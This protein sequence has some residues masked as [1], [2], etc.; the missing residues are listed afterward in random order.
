MVMTDLDYQHIGDNNSWIIG[1]GKS[2][3]TPLESMESTLIYRR[4]IN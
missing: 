4:A 1:H 2:V 3:K